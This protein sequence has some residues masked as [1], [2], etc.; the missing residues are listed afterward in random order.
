[1][2]QLGC[3]EVEEDI[4]GEYDRDELVEGEEDGTASIQL[5]GIE[6]TGREGSTREHVM[7]KVAKQYPVHWSKADNL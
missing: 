4:E 7:D 5:R 6:V 2:E 3:R 1:M